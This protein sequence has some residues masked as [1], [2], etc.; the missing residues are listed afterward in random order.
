MF[1][2]TR[3]T[4][5][6]ILA[7]AAALMLAPASVLQIVSQ[8]QPQTP[9]PVIFAAPPQAAPT[10]APTPA[11]ALEPAQLFLGKRT[12]GSALEEAIKRSDMR[13][14]ERMRVRVVLAIRPDVRTAVETS[15]LEQANQNLN[16]ALSGVDAQLTPEQWDK[17]IDFILKEIMPILLE[18]LRGLIGG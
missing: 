4:Q 3:L 8:D 18:L 1:K 10:P 6:S 7:L 16:M 2:T 17:I 13:I 9:Q 12:I 14:L 11:P 5:F 15:I